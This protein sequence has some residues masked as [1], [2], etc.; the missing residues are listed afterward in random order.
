MIFSL[1]V[2][3]Q[4]ST[5]QWSK[6][7]AASSTAKKA[8][9]DGAS[10]IYVWVTASAPVTIGT[11]TYTSAFGSTG[12]FLVK[13]DT[14]GNIVWSREM[15]MA[16]YNM[17]FNSDSTALLISGLIQSNYNNIDFGNA[18]SVGSSYN[19]AGLIVKVDANNSNTLWI[20]S[21]DPTI[22]TLT[23]AIP[24]HA[25]QEINNRIFAIQGLKIRRLD[26]DGNEIW[27]RVITANGT[28][29]SLEN[30][31]FNTFADAAGNSFYSGVSDMGNTTSLT[32]N[33]TTY[34]I[35]GNNNVCRTYFSL[36]SDGN[37]NWIRTNVNFQVGK[38]VEVSRSGEIVLGGYNIYNGMGGQTNHPFKPDYCNR[39]YNVFKANIK[40]GIPVWE[41][42]AGQVGDVNSSGYHLAAD[43]NLYVLCHIQTAGSVFNNIPTLTR[44]FKNIAAP[45][46]FL[47]RLNANGIPDSIFSVNTFSG[48]TVSTADFAVMNLYRTNAGKFL[49]LFNKKNNA[50]NFANGNANQN[51]TTIKEQGM[52]QF[53]PPTL[54]LRHT[55]TWTGAT[56]G[57]WTTAGNWSNGLPT[58]SSNVV[59]PPGATNYPQF[60]SHLYD[61]GTSQWVKC[62]NL[63][64]Q[65]GATFYFG[66]GGN[67]VS[68]LIVNEGTLVYKNLINYSNYE[69][70]G[71]SDYVGGGYIIGKGTI[72]YTGG[73]GG[74]VPA[75]KSGNNTFEV[76]LDNITD[77]IFFR[78]C[79]SFKNL[80]I[81]KGNIVFEYSILNRFYVDSSFTYSPPSRVYG[82][83]IT[84]TVR[85]DESVTFPIGNSTGLQPATISLYNSTL[86]VYLTA[87]F[88]NVVNGAAPNPATC[89]VNGQSISSVLNRGTWTITSAT[90]LTAGAYYNASFKL[91]GSTN[92]VNANRYALLKRNNNSSEWNVAG[93]YQP[94]RDS[95]GYAIS[96][97]INITS[98][99][100]F[101]I[102]IADAVLSIQSVKLSATKESAGNRLAWN[103]LANDGQSIEIQRSLNGRLFEHVASIPYDA[104]GRYLDAT[105]NSKVWYRLKVTDKSGDEKYSNIVSINNQY[106]QLVHVY[107]TLL[108]DVFYVQNNTDNTLMLQ[109]TDAT[110]RIIWKQGIQK[111][112]NAI[113]AQQWK[114]GI[115]HYRLSDKSGFVQSGKLV[116]Q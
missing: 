59:I 71:W 51:A 2:N 11:T 37:T 24:V 73:A 80:H 41:A 42:Y 77:S 22:P 47:L 7:V 69:F 12:N 19:S 46:T 90:P 84:A 8:I 40:D 49:M 25:I 91:T 30:K 17:G 48:S 70:T 15:K 61:Y 79:N 21:Y 101:A 98:F 111:G 50:M 3:G 93:T 115:L 52:V 26:S 85:N 107:P 9:V 14:N 57:N 33:G 20:K 100:D 76:S 13:Y 60:E 5:L 29:Y 105:T 108:R 35:M 81:A 31:N 34:S 89:M 44:S 86:P 110:G 62:G 45:G 94:A 102:G 82:G 97:A 23:T 53:S 54:P 72:K 109:I 56:N 114:S 106:G 55:T 103:I 6:K 43:G 66:I 88:N 28:T 99:S 39:D 104:S 74:A 32:L 10:N 64:I 38:N 16:V 65:Q 1:H 116:R 112:T 4:L 36:D 83:T 95:S 58:D 27:N 63:F 75:F 96:S 78:Q 92:A 68:G 87:N 113:Q 18:M 67:R